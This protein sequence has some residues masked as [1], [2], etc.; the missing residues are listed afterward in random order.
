MLFKKGIIFEINKKISNILIIPF[1]RH[2][3]FTLNAANIITSW[4]PNIHFDYRNT[5]WTNNFLT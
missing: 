5:I 4:H 3:L 2:F 1:I